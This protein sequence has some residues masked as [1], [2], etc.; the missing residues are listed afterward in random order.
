MIAT[1]CFY[2]QVLSQDSLKKSNAFETIPA[3][4]ASLEL[5]TLTGW[6]HI[7]KVY[8]SVEGNV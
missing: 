8:L 4:E 5:S 6:P 7:V 1:S 2:E 3:D